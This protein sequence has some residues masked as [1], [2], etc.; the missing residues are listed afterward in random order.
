MSSLILPT[1]VAEAMKAQPQNVEAPKSA[2]EEAYVPPVY[3]TDYQNL[4][5]GAS[6]FFPIVA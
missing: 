4:Q 6:L 1:H 3:S 5:D 2:L